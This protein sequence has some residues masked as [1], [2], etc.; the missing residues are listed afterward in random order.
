MDTVNVWD[1]PVPEGYIRDSKGNLVHAS[2]LSEAD[3]MR[4]E[5]VIEKVQTAFDRAETHNDWIEHVVA[6]VYAF[7]QVSAER[8]RT[9][10]GE[11]NSVTLQSFCGRFK[12]MLDSD[13]TVA[14]NESVTI[15][16]QL[17]DECMEEWMVGGKPQA[18]A[19]LKDTFRPGRNG[20]VSIGRLMLVLS[21]RHAAAFKD[22]EKFQRVCDAIEQSIQ[23]TGKRRHVRFYMRRTPKDK[24]VMA[25][26]N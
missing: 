26:F 22:H 23:K 6:D 1:L 16:K 3:R 17:L 15:A 18:V 5:I 19:L 10:F 2:Q 14:V 9:T 11:G 7:C 12:L 20:A 24:W 13:D 25:E 21:H 8:F 4:S